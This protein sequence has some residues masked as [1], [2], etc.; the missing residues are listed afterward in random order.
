MGRNKHKKLKS[1]T[2]LVWL[3]WDQSAKFLI[4]MIPSQKCSYHS[5]LLRALPVRFTFLSAL[6]E[7]KMG[8]AKG[9]FE[10]TSGILY[11]THLDMIVGA[12]VNNQGPWPHADGFGRSMTGARSHAHFWLLFFCTVAVR[13]WIALGTISNNDSTP[14]REMIWE[15]STQHK[16]AYMFCLRVAMQYSKRALRYSKLAQGFTRDPKR[17]S[18]LPIRSNKWPT[19]DPSPLDV[20][21]ARQ[22]V[23]AVVISVIRENYNQWQFWLKMRCLPPDKLQEGY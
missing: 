1:R 23:L 7:P 18:Y 5:H 21:P 14:A 22:L 12:R 19:Q 13:T 17:T 3:V 2:G 20:S 9:T 6:V 16:F 8:S 4:I 11:R 10:T 15:R